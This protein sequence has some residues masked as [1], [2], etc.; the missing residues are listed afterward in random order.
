MLSKEDEDTLIKL[1]RLTDRL[2]SKV[3]EAETLAYHC[4]KNLFDKLVR[5]TPDCKLVDFNYC[6]INTRYDQ[7][8]RVFIGEDGT[9]NLRAYSLDVWAVRMYL[10]SHEDVTVKDLIDNCNYEEDD[11]E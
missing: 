3:Q 6:H 4:Y 11:N 10:E 5:N 7:I 1:E 2:I 8:L 9:H